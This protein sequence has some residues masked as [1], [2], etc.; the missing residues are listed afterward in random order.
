MQYSLGAIS[1]GV[2]PQKK[3]KR[4]EKS[5]ENAHNFSKTYD[6]QSSNGTRA[7]VKRI[8]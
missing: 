6:A 1:F 8:T 2:R 5:K 4:S 7:I 3:E